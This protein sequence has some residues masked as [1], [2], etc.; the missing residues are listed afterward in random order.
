MRLRVAAHR[1]REA[2]VL[3]R[4]LGTDGVLRP[5]DEESATPWQGYLSRRLARLFDDLVDTAG[6]LE[7][8]V[9][10]ER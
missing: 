2:P 7:R 10:G 3:V 4:A 6:A 1:F 5:P 8:L 9:G